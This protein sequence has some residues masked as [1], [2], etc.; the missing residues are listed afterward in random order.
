M[1]DSKNQH[2]CELD[3]HLWLADLA[4]LNVE[5]ETALANY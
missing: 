1:L 2:A 3:E 4:K 5:W